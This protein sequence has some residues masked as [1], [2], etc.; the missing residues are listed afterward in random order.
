MEALLRS[1]VYQELQRRLWELQIEGDQRSLHP[2]LLYTYKIAIYIM[3]VGRIGNHNNSLTLFSV[4]FHNFLAI[5]RSMYLLVR[6]IFSLWSNSFVSIPILFEVD[7]P[8]PLLA[9][10]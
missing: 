7:F 5:L 9:D 8:I 10:S 1:V 3:Y 6:H 4:A 2:E